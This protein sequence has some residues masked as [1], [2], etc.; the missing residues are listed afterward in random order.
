MELGQAI[1][2]ELEL[3]DR[4]SVLERWL[5]HHLSELMSE[6]VNAVGSEKM[7]AEQRAVDIILKLWMHR[8]A[9]P[10]PVDPLGGY[11]DA[12]G[13]LGRLMPEADPWGRFRR[14]DT[15]EDLLH[16]MFET[17]T[18]IVLGGVLLTEQARS[19][20]LSEA[21]TKSLE[22]EE[23]FFI[24]SLDHWMEFFNRLPNTQDVEIKILTENTEDKDAT[25]EIKKGDPTLQQQDGQ[26]GSLHSAILVNLE[27][28]QMNLAR[29]LTRW[30]KA[31]SDET[32]LGEDEFGDAEMRD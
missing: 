29:L 18:R 2:S 28:M 7:A 12:I 27:H 21:E 3:D 14:N 4:G 31:A 11:R 22:E 10:E 32:E 26:E 30:R 17:L 13:V 23:T 9:L 15:A 5:A 6:A 25:S 1:V 16:E 20:L 8:R 24:K 19:R